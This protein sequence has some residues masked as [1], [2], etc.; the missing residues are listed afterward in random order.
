MVERFVWVILVNKV[1]LLVPA[2]EADED[3]LSLVGGKQVLVLAVVAVEGTVTPHALHCG[4]WM[5]A[6]VASEGLLNKQILYSRI[7][8]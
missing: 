5:E 6:S 4:T 2:E 8:I 3:L 1:V 7:N